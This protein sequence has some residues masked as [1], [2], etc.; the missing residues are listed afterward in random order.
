[1]Q[2]GACKA[3]GC[4]VDKIAPPDQIMMFSYQTAQG[5]VHGI[6][7]VPAEATQILPTGAQP[8]NAVGPQIARVLPMTSSTEFV[9]QDFAA[10]FNRGQLSREEEKEL[11]KWYGPVNVMVLHTLH[12]FQETL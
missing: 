3:S 9:N 2:S 7:W 10:S 11:D 8:A 5:V 6:Q 1:L 4:D 12:L